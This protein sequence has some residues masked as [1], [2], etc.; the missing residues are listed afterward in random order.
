MQCPTCNKTDTFRPWEGSVKLLG[1]EVIG[2]GRRCRSC[3]EI[4]FDGAEVER[5]EHAIATALVARGVRTGPEFKLVRKV[6]G[7]RAAALLTRACR[8][9]TGSGGGAASC[10]AASCCMADCWAAF[11]A[12]SFCESA[13]SWPRVSLIMALISSRA[14][15][16]SW[17]C[18]RS[19]AR[20]ARLKTVVHR[21]TATTAATANLGIVLSFSLCMVGPPTGPELQEEAR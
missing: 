6:A 15:S 14:A 2:R 21:S 17:M 7:L 13:W 19:R 12:S 9:R 18:F 20:Y 3:G 5:Q 8:G 4:L 1:I 16:R 10:G 11:K